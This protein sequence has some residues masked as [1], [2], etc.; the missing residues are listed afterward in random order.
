MQQ[1]RDSS[2][3]SNGNQRSRN[4]SNLITTNGV[5]SHGQGNQ[6]QG[7]ILN[8]NTASDINIYNNSFIVQSSPSHN[9]TQ[10]AQPGQRQVAQKRA[11]STTKPGRGKM[12]A[13]GNRTQNGQA[14]VT[15][16]QASTGSI[17]PRSMST[18]RNQKS[19]QNARAVKV[20]AKT[21]RA[22]AINDAYK[23]GRNYLT[24]N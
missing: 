6:G 7:A 20:A 4:I 2:M 22:Q 1:D 12:N 14:Q 13:S 18:G 8:I 11:T 5:T 23:Q 3:A 16:Q 9:M 17:G 24:N 21:S 10:S 19:S 15:H